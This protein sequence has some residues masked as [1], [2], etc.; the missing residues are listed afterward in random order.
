MPKRIK[1]KLGDLFLVPFE[2]ELKGV[3]RI[4][5]KNQATIFIELYRIKPIKDISEFN[6]EIAK[7]EKPLVLNWCYDDGIKSGLWE[8][9]D[10]RP[11]VEEIEMPYFWYKDSF[12]GKYYIEK[13]SEDSYKTIGESIEISKDD[14]HNYNSYG[15]GDEL[16]ETKIYVNRL[17]NEGLM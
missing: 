6:Y 16:F 17:R 10:N 4:L 8:I 15:I 13:G 5:K 3:G 12:F 11:V 9:F 7:N 2:D 14:I 1:Y